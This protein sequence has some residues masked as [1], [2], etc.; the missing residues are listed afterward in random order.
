MNEDRTKRLINLKRRR[1]SPIFG[2]IHG[3]SAITPMLNAMSVPQGRS[4]QMFES[5]SMLTLALRNCLNTSESVAMAC[6][7]DEFEA[8]ARQ[9]REEASRVGTCNNIFAINQFEYKSHIAA[10]H[11][12]KVF[13]GGVPWDMNNDDM[14]EAFRQFGVIAV[15]RP[16]KEVRASRASKDLS[17]AGYL[18]L[19]FDESKSI[20]RLINVCKISFDE[21]GSKYIY[22]LQ[23]KRSRKVKDVQVIPW[24]KEDS[25]Y[26]RSGFPR[27]HSGGPLETAIDESRMI[28]LGALHGM[29]NAKSVFEALEEMYGPTDYVILETDRYDYPM[30][31][32]RAQLSTQDCYLR[33]LSSRFMQVISK[34]FK[35]TIQIDP[36]LQDHKCDHCQFENGPVYCY[37]CKQ[38]FCRN[39]WTVWH[40]VDPERLWHGILMKKVPQLPS[41]SNFIMAHNHQTEWSINATS[42]STTSRNIDITNL[43]NQKTYQMST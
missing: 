17:K 35:K 34:R 28:F 9:H 4:E 6:S 24:D 39:C 32:G 29:M 22:S 11:S 42:Q 40:Q 16:G 33:A 8:R 31:F 30:G 5:S 25:S 41:S 1:M 36:Y 43:N 14:L 20:H 37:E 18:Y 10:Q 19:I 26:F 38:Y 12:V 2:H 15:Q 27:N 23:S 21:E 7:E 3:L 13:L